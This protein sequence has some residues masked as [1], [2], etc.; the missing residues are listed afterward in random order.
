VKW[1]SGAV[2]ELKDVPAR[3]SILIEEGTGIVKQASLRS[4]SATAQASSPTAAP[5]QRRS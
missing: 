4:P 1:P 2:T 5:L 3:Q